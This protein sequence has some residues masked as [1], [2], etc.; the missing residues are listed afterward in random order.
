MPERKSDTWEHLRQ[1]AE[2]TYSKGSDFDD[3]HKIL[4]KEHDDEAMVFAI[5]KKLKS[6]HYADAARTGRKFLVVG[7][8]LILLGFIVTCVNFHSERSITFAMYGLTTIG[9]GFV[10]YGL[11]KLIG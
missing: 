11:Y 6:E 2:E 5:I 10:F 1:I 7:F 9:L 8:C 4:L 3:I